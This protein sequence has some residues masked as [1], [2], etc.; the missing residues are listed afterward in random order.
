MYG[1]FLCQMAME[2]AEKY[3]IAAQQLEDSTKS[4]MTIDKLIIDAGLKIN[5]ARPLL[6][7]HLSKYR[8]LS[9]CYRAMVPVIIFT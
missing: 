1:F 5:Q 7:R 2:E 9:I 6:N 3:K 4:I 8:P